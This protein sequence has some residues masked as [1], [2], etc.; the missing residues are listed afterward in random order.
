MAANGMFG[1]GKDGMINPPDPTSSFM[2]SMAEIAV[3][4][5]KAYEII[6]DLKLL[7]S[8]IKVS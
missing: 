7:L 5:R 2:L 1:A 3:F 6:R 4:N 8:M